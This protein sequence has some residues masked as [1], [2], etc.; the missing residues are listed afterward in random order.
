MKTSQ[1]GSVPQN[2]A[3]PTYTS[4]EFGCR[5]GISSNSCLAVNLASSLRL[6]VT[7]YA[8]PHNGARV[9]PL[10]RPRAWQGCW[11]GLL[12]SLPVSPISCNGAEI[13]SRPCTGEG[14]SSDCFTADT[15]KWALASTYAHWNSWQNCFKSFCMQYFKGFLVTLPF[16]MSNVGTILGG[17]FTGHGD[18]YLMSPC[19]IF[20]GR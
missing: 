2:G 5:C 16:C 10:C 13:S 12:C 11:Q 19:S 1:L 9:Y 8:T 15:S 18:R 7:A 6:T 20:F 4:T 14:C 3:A 17:F